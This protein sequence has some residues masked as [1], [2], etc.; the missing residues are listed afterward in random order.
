MRSPPDYTNYN[1]SK[2]FFVQTY[3]YY[4]QIY[5]KKWLYI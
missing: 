4:F 2:P 3:D 5:H 1:D